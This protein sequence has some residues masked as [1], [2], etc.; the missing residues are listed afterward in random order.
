VPNAPDDASDASVEAGRGGAGAAA[1]GD[2]ATA[3]LAAAGV[4]GRDGGRGSRAGTAHSASSSAEPAWLQQRGA[5]PERGPASSAGAE[6]GRAA[7]LHAPR[8]MS[9][10]AC[11]PRAPQAWQQA[12]AS[13]C[14]DGRG[15]GHAAEPW[16]AGFEPHHVLPRAERMALGAAAKRLIDAGRLAYLRERGMRA[17][18]VQYV[19]PEV[20]GENRLLLATAGCFCR[21]EDLHV[22]AE[23]V[24]LCE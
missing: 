6:G 12:A 14:A 24:R 19:A 16:H 17:R 1:P 4:S 3:T 23:G 20:S 11:G 10:G 2:A 5:G 9:G 13:A 7:A 22:L 15:S 8:D 18:A 21:S